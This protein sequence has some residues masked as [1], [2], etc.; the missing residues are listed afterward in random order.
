MTVSVL[1][2]IPA[3]GGSKGIPR[4]NIRTFGGIPLLEWTVRA[5]RAAVL[6]DRIVVTTDDDDI[7]AVART[8]GAELVKRPASL[9]SDEA[10]SESALLHTLET[11]GQREGFQPEVIAFLQCTAPFTAARDIDGTVDLVLSGAY[12]SAVTMTPFHYFVWRDGARGMIGVN[13]EAEVRLR[14]QDRSPE[15]KEVGAVYS[16]RTDGFLEHKHR[17]F[18]RIGKYI[19]PGIRSLEIDDESDWQRAEAMLALVR[20]RTQPL[21]S[22]PLQRIRAVVT[23]FDGVLTDNRVLVREDGIESVVCNRGDGW[24]IELLRKHGIPVVCISTEANP[25]VAARCKKLGVPYRQGL[26]D[27][28]TAF[29]EFAK[30]E[31]LGTSDCLFVG[32]DTNDIDCLRHAGLAFVPAD[33][34]DEALA[35]ADGVTEARGGGGVLREIAGALLRAKGVGP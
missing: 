6:V 10:S 13:H 32:N 29:R 34:A 24:G 17:F 30:D 31:G 2:I 3:R 35:L 33:A 19:L 15:Y 21:S 23:D 27:K 9:A 8:C 28:L 4:K 18:G 25:V 5:A 26:S 22:L 20:K 7:A 11:L 16:M 12:D 14:R 1:A